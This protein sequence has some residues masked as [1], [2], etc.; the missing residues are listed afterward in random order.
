MKK[1]KIQ[2]TEKTNIL[3][4]IEKN[5]KVAELLLKEGFGCIGSTTAHF[6]TIEQGLK[7]HGY[8]KKQIKEIVKKLNK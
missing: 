8:G 5:S 6:E 2:I 3:K 1:P 7:A 4:A